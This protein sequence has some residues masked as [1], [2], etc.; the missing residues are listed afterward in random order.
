MILH[1]K[2]VQERVLAEVKAG[3]EKF[4]AARG[5]TPTLAVVLVGG[6]PASHVYVGHK[7]RAA[8]VVSRDRSASVGDR[9]EEGARG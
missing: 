5:I 8:D 1:G 9:T 4:K 3:V 2:P 7:R 6:D